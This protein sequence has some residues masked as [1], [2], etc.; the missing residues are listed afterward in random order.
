VKRKSIDV[1]TG[2]PRALTPSEA[3]RRFQKDL[4]G[5]CD[6]LWSFIIRARVGFRCEL[7][8]KDIIVCK[9]PMQGAHLVT[10]NVRSIHWDLRNGRSLCVA[11]HKFYTHNIEAWS[12]ICSQ[13][14]PDDWAYVT[15]VKWRGVKADLDLKGL[16]WRLFKAS[17]RGYRETAPEYREVFKR[18]DEWHERN[19]EVLR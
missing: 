6:F 9:E 11:H 4:R 10:R 12:V 1:V 15:D 8:G 19:A 2:L 17:E 13:Q 7:H 18:L 3:R 14:W 5:H 16:Y